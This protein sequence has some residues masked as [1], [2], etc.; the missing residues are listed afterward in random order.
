VTG[1]DIITAI[2][3]AGIAI[4]VVVYLLYWLY[5]RSSKEVA[6]VRTGLGGEKVVLSGGALVLPIIHDITHVGMKTLR[7][8]VRRG[9]EGALITKDRMR[10][11]VVAEFYL[12][13]RPDKESVSAAAQSLGHRTMDA[14]SLKELVQGRFVDAL[15]TVA[16][17]MTMDEMQEQRGRYVKSVKDLVEHALTQNGLELEAVSLT[18]LDQTDIGMFNPSNAFDA[19]GLT[20][21]TEQ[22]EARNKLRNDIEQDTLI[23]IRN[24]NLEAEKLSLEIEKESQYARLAQEQEV[25]VRRSEQRTEIAIDRAQRDRA[26]E[27]AQIRAQE[28]IEK[29]RIFRE[30]AVEAEASLRETRLTEEI[31]ARRKHRNDVE[32]DTAIQIWSKDL[33]AEK[34]HLDIEKETEFWRLEQKREIAVRRAQQQA[35]IARE[36]AERERDAEEAEIR[37]REEVEKTRIAQEKVLDAERILREQE[38]ERLEVQRRR[39][40]AIEEK[41]RAIAIAEKDRE[42]VEVETTVELARAKEAEAEEKVVSVREKEIAE[43]KKQIELILAAQQAEREAIQLTTI[44]DAE[45]TAAEDRAEADRFA[46]LAAKLRYEIDAEGKRQL[47]DAENMRSDASR[48]SA[49]RMRL[50]EHLEGIIRESVKPMENIDAIKILQVDG[51]PGLSGT[52]PMGGSGGDDSSSEPGGGG[53]S[54]GEG[55]GRRGGS[56]ADNIVSSALRYRAQA[57][58]VDNLLREIG[59]TPNE[60]TNLGD[61]LREEGE[62]QT[63]AGKSKKSKE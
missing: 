29:A 22:I 5:Q 25:A 39:L 35:E 51:L 14:E 32:K 27:E 55:G 3:L 54:A 12:R 48:R 41:E 57:P 7:L 62:G 26:A 31:E 42:Q 11:E 58:F 63:K 21:L 49:L 1:P 38:T 47:N 46:T 18:G 15:S 36:R 19:E 37:A 44:A 17:Q 8:E 52:I 60:I 30:K 24:K 10:V 33:E 16:A 4:A 23:Q 45:K 9:G 28:E 43:R 61:L 13:V 34:Q 20:R 59:M 53:P 6:F 50:V 56:L 40:L 2:L